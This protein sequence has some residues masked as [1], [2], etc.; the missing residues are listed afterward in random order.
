ML[1]RDGENIVSAVYQ[2]ITNAY[3]YLNC[4]SLAALHSSKRGTLKTLTQHAY[5]ICSTTEL[6]DI[7][8][9]YLEKVSEG[10]TTIQNG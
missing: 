8:L 6:L 10:K 2:K 7:E 1:C 3:V 4:N 9:K 5:M